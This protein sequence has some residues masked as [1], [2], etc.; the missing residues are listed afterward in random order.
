MPISSSSV[1]HFTRTKRALKGILK[2][3]FKVSYC[4]EALRYKKT[5]RE[6][7]FPM[8]SFCDIPLSQVKEHIGKYGSYGIGL[9]KKWATRQQL[10]P[11]QYVASGSRYAL[12]ME[13][14]LYKIRPKKPTPWENLTEEQRAVFSIVAYLKNYEGDLK[15]NGKTICDYRFYDEREWRY[16]PE[17]E[18]RFPVAI[19]GDRY[20]TPQQKEKMNQKLSD[21]RLT[22]EPSD[23]KYIIVKS[24]EDISEFVEA[25]RNS[26]GKSYTQRETERLTTRIIT[27]EQIK[28]DL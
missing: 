8:V 18:G 10:N 5:H 1:F 6:N 20:Q 3:N 9:T 11:V 26:N 19:Q 23:I 15:R 12:A 24:E 16:V 28:S 25:I 27:T 22:F 21:L 14:L 2:H 4:L 7:A 17:R 13:A